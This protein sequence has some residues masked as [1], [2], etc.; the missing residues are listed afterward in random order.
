M[1][2]YMRNTVLQPVSSVLK[3][4]DRLVSQSIHSISFDAGNTAVADN[5]WGHLQ[6]DATSLYLL[7]LGE[8]TSSGLHIV[9]TLDEVDFVQNLVFYIEQSYMI[10]VSYEKN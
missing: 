8:M 10:P 4:E 9:Y 2:L 1:I 7:M 6:M 5:E 3:K